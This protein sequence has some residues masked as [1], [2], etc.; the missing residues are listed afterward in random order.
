M[1]KQKTVKSVA[2]RVKVTGRGKLKRRKAGRRHLMASKSSKRSRQLRGHTLIAKA[3][4]VKMKKA[5]GM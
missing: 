3:D 5:L 2:K 1:P 4:V